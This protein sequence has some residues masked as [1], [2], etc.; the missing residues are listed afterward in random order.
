L[1]LQAIPL[2]NSRAAISLLEIAALLHWIPTLQGS[3][4]LHGLRTLMT[5]F[6][7]FLPFEADFGLQWRYCLEIEPYWAFFR[8]IAAMES[9]SNRNRG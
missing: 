7:N 9:V 3:I 2:K 5:L 1:K 6:S 8:T 4:H